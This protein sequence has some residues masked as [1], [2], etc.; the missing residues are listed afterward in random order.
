LIEDKKIRRWLDL[1]ENSFNLV[2]I[3]GDHQLIAEQHRR[4]ADVIRQA[5][6]ASQALD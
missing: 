4:L 3:D 2:F 6:R 5:M 1:S